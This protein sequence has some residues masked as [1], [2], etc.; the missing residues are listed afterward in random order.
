MTRTIQPDDLLNLRFLNGAALSPDATKVL[1]T[2]NKIE[3]DDNKEYCTLFLLDRTSGEARQMTRGRAVDAGPRWSPDSKTIALVSN[4]DGK[5]QLYLLPAD[6]GEARQLTRF[7]RGIGGG[8]AWSP[9]GSKIAFCAQAGRGSRG[10]VERALPR[11]P[12]C[13][14][15]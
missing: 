9:D 3:A 12:Y 4:R 13:L 1:Y 14:P 15:L 10:P 8:L 2:V 11:R 7:K 6:G 5:P